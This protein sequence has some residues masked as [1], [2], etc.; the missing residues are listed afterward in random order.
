LRRRLTQ[1]RWN[2][3]T[4]CLAPVAAFQQPAWRFWIETSGSSV[5]SPGK[6]DWSPNNINETGMIGQLSRITWLLRYKFHL[7]EFQGIGCSSNF[8]VFPDSWKHYDLLRDQHDNISYQQYFTRQAPRRIP[9]SHPGSHPASR[10][11][12]TSMLAND[13]TCGFAER[14]S[15]PEIPDNCRRRLIL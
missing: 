13:R 7:S 4:P 9:A 11:V 15:C 1:P 6:F 14:F 2:G 10:C 12:A 3:E 5:C 8:P